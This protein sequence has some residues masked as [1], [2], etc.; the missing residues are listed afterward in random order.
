MT[1][2][3]KKGSYVKYKAADGDAITFP[4]LLVKGAQKGPTVCITAGIH[5]CEY[6][7]VLAAIALYK[8]LNYETLR[9]TVK[10]IPIVDMEA[11]KSKKMFV[12]P[13]DNKNINR[14][15]PGSENGTYSERLVYHLVQNFI[16]GSDYYIDLHSA[17]LTEAMSPFCEIHD[18]EDKRV[19]EVSLKMAKY[20][21][22]TDIVIKSA[23]GEINDRN[24]SYST[25]AD[26]GIPSLVMNAGQIG[27]DS[28]KYVDLILRGLTNILGFMKVLDDSLIEL[29][30]QIY[31][32]APIH[33]RAKAEGIFYHHTKVGEQVKENEIIGTV[34]DVF[35]TELETLRAPADGK[36]LLVNTGI[37]VKRGSLLI[38][39]IVPK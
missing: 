30:N 22:L 13:K 17:D 31:Y 21:G 2:I 36:V 28:E 29:E 20:S 7:P 11:F 16:K 37:Y 4:Y 1:I 35:G 27:E 23:E 33:I 38:E 15:F 5:G 34:E 8:R 26:M 24:Q 12:C 32:K 10:I 14:C 9:G 18:S 6:P 25:A 3:Y 39:I 19:N